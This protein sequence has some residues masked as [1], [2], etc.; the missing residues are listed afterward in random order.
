M[1]T[2]GTPELWF[3]WRALLRVLTIDPDKFCLEWHFLSSMP[4]PVFLL[5]G[6]HQI[7][8]RCDIYLSVP[9]RPCTWA[10]TQWGIC[11]CI[12]LMLW[13]WRS[14]WFGV[15]L[16]EA[17]YMRCMRG[18]LNIVEDIFSWC[19]NTRSC[20]VPPNLFAIDSFMHIPRAFMKDMKGTSCWDSH[21]RLSLSSLAAFGFYPRFR[22]K[23]TVSTVFNIS[24][25]DMDINP[26]NQCTLKHEHGSERLNA[27]HMCI[28]LFGVR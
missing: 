7:Q 20:L 14:G 9:D 10:E 13:I 26:W 15:P 2:G 11:I 24:L 22:E 6:V 12:P 21:S 1:G 5:D 28:Y 19:G 17:F 18:G 23:Q 3:R 8:T 25:W 4:I 27:I 16:L